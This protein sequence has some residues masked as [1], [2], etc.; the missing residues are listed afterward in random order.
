MNTMIF[1]RSI[2]VPYRVSV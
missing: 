2:T 1:Q